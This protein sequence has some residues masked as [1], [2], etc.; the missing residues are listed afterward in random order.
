MM[1]GIRTPDRY[2]PSR[3]TRSFKDSQLLLKLNGSHKRA[4]QFNQAFVHL[5]D[6][7]APTPSRNSRTMLEQYATIRTPP[8]APRSFGLLATRAN[9]AERTPTRTGSA[10]VV[11]SVGGSIVTEGVAS[12]T[13]GR[14]GR[15]TS[16]TSAPHYIAD[17]L[18]THLPSEEE[19][20]H[21]KRLAIALDADA[22]VG[23]ERI[24]G[25][26]DHERQWSW[27]NGGWERAGGIKRMC[28]SSSW[29]LVLTLNQPLHGPL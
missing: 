12:V 2:I 25:A 6:P 8:P 23:A 27:Q 9:L 1:E 10:G 11:W 28:L 24:V 14:G 5:Q 3:K 13:N 22:D 19:V 26:D 20:R 7:F 21:G 17:F 16:G 29:R 4:T 18:K 15:V